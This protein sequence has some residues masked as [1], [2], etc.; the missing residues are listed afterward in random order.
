M[1]SLAAMTVVPD[2]LASEGLPEPVADTRAALIEAASTCDFVTLQAM[3][4]AGGEADM[5][6]DMI[7]WGAVHDLDEFVQHDAQ[8]GTLRSLFL[9]LLTLPYGADETEDQVWYQWPDVPTLNDPD[10]GE[11]RSI[12]EFW[13]DDMLARVAFVNDTTS[14]D[15]IS[16]T[17]DVLGGYGLFRTAI[18]D[19]GRWWFAGAGD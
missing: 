13:D 5:G 12:T 2:P 18:L 4:L 11:Q 7:F 1:E 19:D 6:Y 14:E 9:T 17:D 3:A 16:M 10:T 15:V 8:Y